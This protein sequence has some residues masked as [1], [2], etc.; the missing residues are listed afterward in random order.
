MEGELR[1]QGAVAGFKGGW[2][3]SVCG[4]SIFYFI[5]CEVSI[6]FLGG[7]LDVDVGCLAACSEARLKGGEGG[8][9]RGHD[10]GGE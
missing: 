10:S 5:L 2:S 9:G 8:R 7:Y 1:G 3:V 6:F 4:I